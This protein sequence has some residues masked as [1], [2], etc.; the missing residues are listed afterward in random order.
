M[1]SVLEVIF[2]VQFI[3]F[4]AMFL[5]RVYN[6]ITVG[7]F[8]KN[9]GRNT[10]I[11]LFIGTLLAYGLG[12]V[13]M[14]YGYET[15]FYGTLMTLESWMLPFTVVMFFAELFIYLWLPLGQKGARYVPD[16]GR[17]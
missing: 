2:L 7:E 12:I 15:L 14:I 9:N 3:A 13:S 8:F 6:L 4:I 11:M 5:V 1:A 16:G 17:R 10:A